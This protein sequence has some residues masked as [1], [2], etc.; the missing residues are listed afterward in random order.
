MPRGVVDSVSLRGDEDSRV[1][2]RFLHINC[3]PAMI[4]QVVH[5]GHCYSIMFLFTLVEAL[6]SFEISVVSLESPLAW[7][8]KGVTVPDVEERDECITIGMQGGV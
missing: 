2:G 8:R 7:N 5:N 4:W 6:Y 3:G 1:A